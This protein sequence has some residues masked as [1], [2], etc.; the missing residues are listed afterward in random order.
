VAG[1]SQS[2][3]RKPLPPRPA[4]VAPSKPDTAPEPVDTAKTDP[5]VTRAVPMSLP[6]RVAPSKG[7]RIGKYIVERALGTGGM[8]MVVAA[9]HETLE[10]MVAIKL[11]H[12]KLARDAT[13]AERF[14]REARATAK[15]KSEHVVRVL[16]AGADEISGA[17]FIVMEYLLGK[18]VGKILTEEGPIPWQNAVELMLQVLEAVASAHALGIVHR[19]LKPANFFVT[20]RPDGSPLV[21]VLDFG[22]SKA[23]I[24]NE[25]EDDPKLTET[26]A[27]FGSPTYMSPEQIRSSKNVDA[28]SD[29]WSLG[30]AFFEILTGRLPFVADNV[31]GLLASIVTD[32][33]FRIIAFISDVP[34][35]LEAVVLRC[36]EK[37]PAMRVGSVLE[38]ALRLRPFA[39]PDGVSQIE[40]IE[41]IA[42]GQISTGPIALPPRSAK[43]LPPPPPTPP[44]PPAQSSGR[45]LAAAASV[46]PALP[47]AP[48]P[49]IT[50]GTTDTDLAAMKPHRRNAVAVLLGL[51]GAAAFL[52]A[53]IVIF[54][55]KKEQAPIATT[56]PPTET[57]AAA[58]A[59]QPP[60]APVVISPPSAIASGATTAPKGKNQKLLRPPGS[61]RPPPGPSPHG[62]NLDIRY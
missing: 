20:R 39:S 36:L 57:S 17:P 55:G 12:P 9:R 23:L 44:P 14:A 52:V 8:G 56:P 15:I 53:M 29:I 50:I 51:A 54:G 13:Q 59:P 60:S 1:G 5:T 27:V 4:S 21:K 33:P 61:A 18:E 32:E 3:G 10:E 2:S 35:E 49:P 24:L 46:P 48:A 6:L 28:R 58:A 26:Q 40:R 34:P 30:V 19:D 38:L 62:P 25:G 31:A 47:S 16:D 37:D 45:A 22:I 41:R 11:L 43:S 7:D 42:N